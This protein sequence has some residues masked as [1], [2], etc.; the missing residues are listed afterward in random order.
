[1]NMY[2]NEYECICTYIHIDIHT[3]KLHEVMWIKCIVNSQ[4]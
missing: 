3:H 4:V 1:M 2:M